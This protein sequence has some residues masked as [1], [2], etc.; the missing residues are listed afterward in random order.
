MSVP[1]YSDDTYICILKY[2]PPSPS[3]PHPHTHTVVLTD[4]LWH[5][6]THCLTDTNNQKIALFMY[7][8]N[9]SVSLGFSWSRIADALKD[10]H[11]DLALS[12]REKYCSTAHGEIIHRV[13]HCTGMCYSNCFVCTSHT[14]CCYCV[15][16][17]YILHEPCTLCNIID[18]YAIQYHCYHGCVY[19]R[20]TKRRRALGKE[21]SSPDLKY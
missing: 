11:G 14:E 16:F 4:I 20:V 13:W 8:A 19:S 21:K 5:T 7:I 18:D 10:I 2:L 15:N 1:N 12:I 3:H 6:Q 9:N 17:L